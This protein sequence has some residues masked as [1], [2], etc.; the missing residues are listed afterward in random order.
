MLRPAI[1]LGLFGLLS[2]PIACAGTQPASPRPHQPPL[3]LEPNASPDRQP[4]RGNAESD[5][6]DRAAVIDGSVVRWDA[7]H[8]ALADAAGRVVLEEIAL[9]RSLAR[10]A[11]RAGLV[12]TDDMVAAEE[13]A[14]L[15]E[16]AIVTGSQSRDAVLDQIRR[17]RGLGPTRYASLLRRNATLRAL[18]IENADPSADELALARLIAFG[19][20]R[21]LRLYVSG[22]D[23]QAGR[24]R[25]VAAAASSDAR[26]WIF[27]EQ[28]AASSTHPTASIGGL[29]ARFSPSDP[30]YPDVLRDAADRL[31]PGGVSPILATPGGFAVV[32]VESI[33]AGRTP[34]QAETERVESRVRIRK[35]R[36]AMERL[37]QDLLG[38]AAVSP[39]D[40]DLARAWRDR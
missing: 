20:A 33:E 21:R 23:A 25:S 15:D 18:T 27:A 10:A 40:P 26:N 17:S 38:R 11:T 22:S 4:P 35:Q 19:P 12:V 16:L 39:I 36:I 30:A 37:A 24:A 8:P 6:S 28:C 31:E 14:L 5:R 3:R 29:I 7:L 9:D 2:I 1:L 34:S 32:L 13:L